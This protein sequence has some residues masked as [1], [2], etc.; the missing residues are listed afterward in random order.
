MET[1]KEILHTVG[2]IEGE[3][4]EIRNLSTRVRKL[5]LWQSWINGAWFGLTV[6]FGWLCISLYG[7]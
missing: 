6:A 3:L 5:E 2:R 7:K 4:N 1:L